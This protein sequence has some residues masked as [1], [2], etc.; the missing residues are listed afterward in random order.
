[1]AFSLLIIAAGDTGDTSGMSGQEEGDLSPREIV[2]RL[3]ESGAFD[4]RSTRR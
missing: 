2:S 3:L 4:G 1:M